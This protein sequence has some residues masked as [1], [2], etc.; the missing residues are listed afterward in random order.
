MPLAWSRDVDATWREHWWGT[1]NGWMKDVPMIVA[2]VGSFAPY[3]NPSFTFPER[4]KAEMASL[5]DHC[6]SVYCRDSLFGDTFNVPVHPCPSI[7]SMMDMGCS[8]EL[9]LCNMM[10]DGAH[11]SVYNPQEAQVWAEIRGDVARALQ[12]QGFEF[13]AHTEEEARLAENLGFETIHCYGEFPETLLSVYSKAKR[14][15]GNRVHGAIVS[16]S[17]GANAVCC[18]YDSRLLA[19]GE[20][21]AIDWL[22]SQTLWQIG[23][24]METSQPIPGRTEYN[25]RLFQEQLQY[26]R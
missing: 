8:N 3:P 14:Y 13:V 20:A 17:V 7:F 22:P 6:K 9:N 26:F 18:G 2:G 24:W 5:F 16:A 1:F 21:C 19:A 23:H 15:F 25:E 12:G 11:Y 10:P 4:L